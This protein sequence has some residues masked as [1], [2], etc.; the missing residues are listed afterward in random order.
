[1][2]SFGLA[3][4]SGSGKTTLLVRLL[5]EIVGRGLTVS[6]VKH[7]HHSF[8]LDRRGKDSHS[9]RVAGAAEVM[10][11]SSA[12]WALLHELRDAPEPNVEDLIGRMAP[13]DLVLIEGFKRYPHAKLEVHRPSIGKPFLYENDPSVVAVASDRPLQGVQLPLFDLDD[14]RGIADFIVDRCR[15]HARAGDH[16]IAVY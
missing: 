10:I 1:M 15:L 14:I 3:G 8:D 6:T 2:E 11:A 9:H 13:V 4:W 12:R 7:T 5:P 16:G